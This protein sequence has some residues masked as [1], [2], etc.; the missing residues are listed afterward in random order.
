MGDASCALSLCRCDTVSKL[1]NMKRHLSSYFAL[2][3]L[4]PIVLAAQGSAD[5]VLT[6]GRIYT[7]DNARPI[8]PALAVRGSRILFV[9]SAAEARVLANSSTRVVDLHGAT[10]VPG[11]IDAHAPLLGLGNMLQSANVAGSNSYQEVI[12]R[13]R[14]HARDVK[15]GA[16]IVGRGWD[17]TR[18]A[19]KEFPTHA[20][21]SRAFPNNPVVLERIDGHALLA[22]ARAMELAH[23]TSATAEP[24][25]G[26][27]LRLA[28]GSPSGVFI[29]NASGLIDRAI[30][31]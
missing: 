4:A 17:Q 5:L 29:D 19:S 21:V 31:A 28:S 2:A 7:V 3:A 9:G 25:G 20:E 11:I 1:P 14:A 6:N 18:C 10:V 13:V 22:N 15:P 8:V 27:I 23:V 16:W 30:P 24:A 26:R 12:D